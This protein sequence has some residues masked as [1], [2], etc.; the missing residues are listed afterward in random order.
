[1]NLSLN[2]FLVSISGLP[3]VFTKVRILLSACK[4]VR[5]CEKATNE[6][7]RILRYKS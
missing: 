5:G 2:T 6:D 3:F 7:I 1:M 4:T